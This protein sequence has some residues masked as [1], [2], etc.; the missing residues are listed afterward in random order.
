VTALEPVVVVV[1]PP[2]SDLLVPLDLSWLV[3]V[4]VAACPEEEV[5]PEEGADVD[6]LLAP[7]CSLATT[8]PI[9]ATAPAVPSR[10]DL[11]T[12]RNRTIARSRVSGECVSFDRFMRGTLS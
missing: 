9:S 4:V 12:R 1:V 10:T 2:D 5:S 6:E 11:V 7:G 8:T 3:V